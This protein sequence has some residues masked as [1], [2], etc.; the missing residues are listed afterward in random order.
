MFIPKWHKNKRLKCLETNPLCPC[1]LSPQW[2]LLILFDTPSQDVDPDGNSSM[3]T[4]GIRDF[5]SL[6][7]HAIVGFPMYRGSGA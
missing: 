2:V 7:F 3:L 4:P 5:M 1:P 6:G